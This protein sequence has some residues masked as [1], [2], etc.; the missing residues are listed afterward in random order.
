M[1]ARP[2]AKIERRCV[3]GHSAKSPCP[4]CVRSQL[5]ARNARQRAQSYKAAHEL[6]AGNK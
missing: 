6:K 2:S 1:K 3:H 5:D 4:Q